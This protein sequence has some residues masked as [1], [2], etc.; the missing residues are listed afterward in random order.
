MKIVCMGDSIT[1]GLGLE[2]DLSRR[3]TD[4]T[5]QKTGIHM[6]NCG[7]SGDT[8]GGML[9]RC[10]TEVFPE[11]PDY[12]LILGGTNDICLAGQY[13]IPCMNIAAMV[14]QADAW[15]IPVLIGIPLPIAPEDMHRMVWDV[16]RDNVK[17]AGECKKL[18]WWLTNYCKERN[19]PIVDFRSVFVKKDGS[20]RRNLFQDGV[21]PT[22]EGHR[23]MAEQVCKVLEP[24][25]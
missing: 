22:A 2:D 9:A 4:L 18:S 21:H 19:I 23:L 11:Q 7:I 8:T 13:R 17:N 12:L 14:K 1:S 15:G 10:Q 16:E 24:L 6:I 20:V 3:W 5:E 25:L